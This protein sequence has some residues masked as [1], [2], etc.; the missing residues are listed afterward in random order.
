[1]GDPQRCNVSSLVAIQSGRTANM[2]RWPPM[3]SIT[4]VSTPGTG[5]PSRSNAGPS[6][7]RASARPSP[8]GSID[9]DRSRRTW[10]GGG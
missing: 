6:T 2:A 9:S 5:S 10:W 1:M 3:P 8:V 4:V 7:V